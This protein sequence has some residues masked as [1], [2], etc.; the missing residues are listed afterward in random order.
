MTMTPDPSFY[1]SPKDAMEAPL[2]GLAF[3]LMLSPGFFQT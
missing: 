2:E 3:A 1:P